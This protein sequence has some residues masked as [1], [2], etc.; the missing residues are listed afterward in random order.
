VQ[1]APRLGP[2]LRVL[3]AQEERAYPLLAVTLTPWCIALAGLA[4][5]MLNLARRA[6][7]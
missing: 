4:S 6:L 1:I 5:Q 7:G 2:A 3:S